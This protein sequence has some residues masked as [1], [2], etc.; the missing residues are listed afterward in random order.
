MDRSILHELLNSVNNLRR[1]VVDP[2]FKHRMDD[3][4]SPNSNTVFIS[5]TMAR[6]VLGPEMFSILQDSLK[7]NF[8]KVGHRVLSFIPRPRSFS[9][10]VTI[11]FGQSPSSGGVLLVQ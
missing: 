2:T 10:G 1:L 8:T 4:V 3:A 7:I 5:L 9:I 6:D 11:L